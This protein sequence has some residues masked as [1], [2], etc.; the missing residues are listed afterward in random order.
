MTTEEMLM[1]DMKPFK[2]IEFDKTKFIKPVVERSSLPSTKPVEFYLSTDKR[3]DEKSELGSIKGE[4]IETFRAIPIPNFSLLHK[5][6]ELK[7]E[8]SI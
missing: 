4:E 5:K 8:K 2:A 3:A 1:K 7:F 6:N